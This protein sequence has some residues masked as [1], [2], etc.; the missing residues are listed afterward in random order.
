MA[1]RYLSLSPPRD[2]AAG[3]KFVE[4]L[5]KN[6]DFVQ[7]QVLEEI[8]K[9]NAKSEYLK[10]FL[11]GKFDKENFKEKVPI[12]DYEDIS[13]FIER[14]T[15]VL[16]DQSSKLILNAEPIVELFRR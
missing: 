14:L 5:I 13:P 16:S 8:L 15:N 7:D 4:E 3:M 1:T 11:H 2:V 10:Q 9:R 6:A 12:V